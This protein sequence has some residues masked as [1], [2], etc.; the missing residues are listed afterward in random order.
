VVLEKL[1]ITADAAA[2]KVRELL[3]VTA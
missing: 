3:A 2:E 1:G